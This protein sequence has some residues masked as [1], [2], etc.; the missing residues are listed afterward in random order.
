MERSIFCL[1][2]GRSRLKT[3]RKPE[4]WKTTFCGYIF[5]FI[6]LWVF[7]EVKSYGFASIRCMMIEKLIS[8]RMTSGRLMC[9]QIVVSSLQEVH[10]N[11]CE[12]E[13]IIDS[14]SCRLR[15]E[16]HLR[17]SEG[18]RMGG[19][20]GGLAQKSTV[21]FSCTLLQCTSPSINRHISNTAL[22][23]TVYCLMGEIAGEGSSEL[24]EDEFNSKQ[25]PDSLAPSVRVRPSHLAAKAQFM[26]LD[27]SLWASKVVLIW[28][29]SQEPRKVANLRFLGFFQLELEHSYLFGK[30]AMIEECWN[31]FTIYSANLK[32]S[33]TSCSDTPSV[34]M[35]GVFW[36]DECVYGMAVWICCTGLGWEFKGT[37]WAK[38]CEQCA[39]KN[40]VYA[41]GT[42]VVERSN[43]T[44]R[45][46]SPVAP[47]EGRCYR[48]CV[49]QVR[50]ILA[51]PATEITVRGK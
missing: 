40:V 24:Q 47:T 9:C 10:R 23:A 19:R 35:F 36:H 45:A 50:T 33:N 41:G 37:W 2:Q 44:D 39:V 21:S 18:G 3:S 4:T 11:S 32:P 8:E 49:E 6:I 30:N 14:R 51:S 26:A 5:V 13:K 29:R 15:E 16:E 46:S 27:T 48:D 42:S 7:E 28:R 22:T 12:R 34:R 43:E 38:I 1:F 25:S 20:K 17:N 31:D